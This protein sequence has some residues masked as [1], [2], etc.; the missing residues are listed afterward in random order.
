MCVRS[1]PHVPAASCSRSSMR[2]AAAR[3]SSFSG[4]LAIAATAWAK[5]PPFSPAAAGA[6]ESTPS[7][8]VCSR[9]SA[10]VEFGVGAGADTAQAILVRL[11]ACGRF[12]VFVSASSRPAGVELAPGSSVAASSVSC[13]P[14]CDSMQAGTQAFACALVFALFSGESV[15]R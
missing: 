10:S 2:T 1:A 6:A 8:C 7:G 13:A 9:S 11:A 5:L 3:S 14:S 12:A 4:S 15:G